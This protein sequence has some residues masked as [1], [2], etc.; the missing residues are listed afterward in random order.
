[1][2]STTNRGQLRRRTAKSATVSRGLV[3]KSTSPRTATTATPGRTECAVTV[4]G[5]TSG[6]LDSSTGARGWQL[7]GTGARTAIMV[8]SSVRALS[9]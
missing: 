7:D 9:Y 4:N 5:V 2:R 6:L 1:M 3:N 8:S